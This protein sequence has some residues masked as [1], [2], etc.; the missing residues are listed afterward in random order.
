[1]NVTDET[2]DNELEGFINVYSETVVKPLDGSH[3]NGITVGVSNLEQAKIAIKIAETSSSTSRVLVQEMVQGKQIYDVRVLCIGGKFIGAIHRIPA[4][5]RGDGEHTLGE[6]I[7][8]ENSTF[9]GEAYKTKFAYIDEKRAERY[10]GN[11]IDTIP[12]KDEVVRVID[13]A[14][15]GAGGELIDV[16]DDIPEWIKEEAIKAGD[17]L[18]VPVAGVDYLISTETIKDATPDQAVIIEV[19]KG[20]S[21]AIHDE[22]TVGISRQ[23]TQAYVDLLEQL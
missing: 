8:I 6:L 21:L 23:A 13:V 9:R 19:N 22:P 7:R 4:Q 2:T 18:D 11:K 5:V 12:Q 10:L 14:N 3:G 17:I 15:Y 1:M 16:T 20:P